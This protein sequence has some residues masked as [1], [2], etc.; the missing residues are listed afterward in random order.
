[1]F[2]VLVGIEFYEQTIRSATRENFEEVMKGFVGLV[3]SPL[4]DDMLEEAVLVRVNLDQTSQVRRS[5]AI[6]IPARDKAI[7]LLD[8]WH[9]PAW[10]KD[11]CNQVW[12]RKPYRLVGCKVVDADVLVTTSRLLSTGV[13]VQTCRLI[14]L[15]RTVGSMTE[16]KQIL[17]RGTRVHEDTDKRYFTMIDFRGATNHALAR[18]LNYGH[19]QIAFSGLREGQPDSQKLV[20]LP[21]SFVITATLAGPEVTPSREL[22]K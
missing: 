10:Q 20:N 18:R 3:R 1:M 4:L 14:V 13:D 22:A 11:R 19:M 17:G 12:T 8:V 21:W 5:Q 15:D 6:L 2:V 16:F 7:R 9:L